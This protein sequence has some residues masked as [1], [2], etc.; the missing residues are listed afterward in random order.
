MAHAISPRVNKCMHVNMP[1]ERTRLIERITCCRSRSPGTY[2]VHARS[3]HSR[4]AA[5]AEIRVRSFR[6][7][8]AE[9]GGN[10]WAALC[11]R[12]RGA[13]A[14]SAARGSRCRN[15]SRT[16]LGT[17]APRAPQPLSPTRAHTASGRH[18]RTHRTPTRR[19]ARA[20]RRWSTAAPAAQPRAAPLRCWRGKPAA[21]RSPP[22][23][24]PAA[25]AAAR[26]PPR[27]QTR[28]RSRS[29]AESRAGHTTCCSACLRPRPRAESPKRCSR[30]AR[31][32]RRAVW[33]PR[34]R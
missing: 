25:R 5:R 34:T 10:C 29:R 2:V 4:T 33:R 26:P 31:P 20:A 28:P 24:S 3:E 21:R 22:L 32:P 14:W 9:R 8:G 11:G 27:S 30:L 15:G 7:H 17:R 23:G 12:R 19:R 16:R 6:R 13:P 1:Y 18:G